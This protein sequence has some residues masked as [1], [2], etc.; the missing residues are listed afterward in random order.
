MKKVTIAAFVT[1]MIGLLAIGII[2]GGKKTSS[3][4]DISSVTKVPTSGPDN[5]SKNKTAEP[6][7]GPTASA[8][9][10][11][12]I[13]VYFGNARK[14]PQSCYLVFPVQRK[15]TDTKSAMNKSIEELL[16]GPTQDETSQGYY[17]NI[18]P[19]VKLQ[20]VIFSN[21]TV[22]VDFDN[23]LQTGVNG[24]CRIVTIRSQITQTLHQ[25]PNITN[26]IISINN[27]TQGILFPNPAL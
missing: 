27:K 19:G 11:S 18:P 5:I 26:V 25:F 22:R 9:I 13:L 12:V 16:K 3:G 4:N 8:Q 20:R 17:S 15:I 14:D 2:A 6:T 23:T 21:G 24:V 1:I 10:S 7:S